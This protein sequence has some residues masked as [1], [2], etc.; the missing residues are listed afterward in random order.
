MPPMPLCHADTL[1]HCNPCPTATLPPTHRYWRDRNAALSTLYEQLQQANVRRMVAVLELTDAQMLPGFRYQS[2]ELTKLRA[3]YGCVVA[4]MACICC[5]SGMRLSL[6]RNG[7]C[8]FFFFCLL[9]LTGHCAWHCLLLL[10]LL[11][12]FICCCL[13]AVLFFPCDAAMS[14]VHHCPDGT[15]AL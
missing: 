14:P 7:S 4:A 2:Q 8:F 3:R 12:L 15:S 1:P 5:H 13:F 9:C 6:C 11:L 10:L